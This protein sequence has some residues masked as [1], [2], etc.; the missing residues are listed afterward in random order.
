M[1]EEARDFDWGV[2]FWGGW[3]A[4]QDMTRLMSIMMDTDWLENE[5]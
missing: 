1:L 5:V 4:P 2:V 3:V